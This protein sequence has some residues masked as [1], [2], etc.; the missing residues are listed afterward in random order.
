MKHSIRCETLPLHWTLNI[1]SQYYYSSTINNHLVKLDFKGFLFQIKLHQNRPKYPENNGT[2]EPRVGW[3]NH[4]LGITDPWPL[5]SAH[6]PPDRSAP[7][8]GRGH[9]PP[10]P[11]WCPGAERGAA[12]RGRAP[13]RSRSSPLKDR[14]THTNWWD[15]VRSSGGQTQK[16]FDLTN[17]ALVFYSISLKLS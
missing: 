13:A 11:P 5:G 14:I 2:P 9:R 7:G 3:V 6:L 17:S 15:R 1:C 8:S 4:G 12:P 10:A 16:Y